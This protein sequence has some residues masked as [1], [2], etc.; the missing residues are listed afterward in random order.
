MLAAAQR[1]LCS[2][3]ARWVRAPSSP[4]YLAEPMTV[5]LQ[6]LAPARITGALLN[7]FQQRLTPL[8]PHLSDLVRTCSTKL[9]QCPLES[10]LGQQE[11]AVQPNHTF[12]GPIGRVSIGTHTDES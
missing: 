9:L 4:R 7:Q 2:L 11:L 12:F 5:Q 6:G 8:P 1:P 10:G 3:H